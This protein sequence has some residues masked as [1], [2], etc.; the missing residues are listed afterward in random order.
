[1]LSIS[2]ICLIS[3]VHLRRWKC[4]QKCMKGIFKQH[5]HKEVQFSSVCYTLEMLHCCQKLVPREPL[6]FFPFFHEPFVKGTKH[7][8]V[9]LKVGPKTLQSGNWP[10]RIWASRVVFSFLFYSQQSC[11]LLQHFLNQSFLFVVINNQLPRRENM[12]YFMSFT[13]LTAW[14]A[15]VC[16]AGVWLSEHQKSDGESERSKAED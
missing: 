14:C 2:L 8:N 6:H 1:M 5:V 7:T 12:K 13:Q 11:C 3:R 4:Q 9:I 10:E 16:V 15:C